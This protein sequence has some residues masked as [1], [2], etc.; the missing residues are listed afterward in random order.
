MTDR[1][2]VFTV[3]GWTERCQ[4]CM[5]RGSTARGAQ[6]LS[7]G[8]KPSIASTTSPS[9]LWCCLDWS[10]LGCSSSGP[11]PLS[12]QPT[13]RWTNAV[14]TTRLWSAS[15][16]PVPFLRGGTS[17]VACTPVLMY[18]GVATTPRIESRQVCFKATLSKWFLSVFCGVTCFCSSYK[19]LWTCFSS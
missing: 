11:T 16:P 17:A 4:A 12:P 18:T 7:H 15:L 13:G 14:S 10:P 19:P 2:L 8:W 9:S 6:L 3:A 1:M 5:P